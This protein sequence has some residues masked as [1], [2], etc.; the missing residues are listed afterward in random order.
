M[1]ISATS[2][3]YSIAVAPRWFRASRCSTDLIIGWSPG[4]PNERLAKRS[5][6]SL[7]KTFRRASEVQNNPTIIPVVAAALINREGLVLMQQRPLHKAHG[8]L[9][10]FPGG[11]VEQGETLESALVREIAEELA[12]ALDPE[13]LAPLTFAARR[14]QP[15]VVMLYTCRRWVGDPVGLDAAEIGWFASEALSALEMPPLDVPL[16]LALHQALERAN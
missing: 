4:A 12:I 13:S 16:A 9:W 3:P 15:H 1:A 11:K 7:T 10:E 14:D 5:H 2:I 8:G 6:H